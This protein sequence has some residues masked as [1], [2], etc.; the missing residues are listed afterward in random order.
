MNTEKINTHS[1]DGSRFYHYKQ[2]DRKS[3]YRQEDE[4][5]IIIISYNTPILWINK[6]KRIAILNERYYSRTTSKHKSHA[7]RITSNHYD[8]LIS[9]EEYNATIKED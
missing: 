2:I 6:V 3:L 5:Q 1:T 7:L 9:I 8:K 4:E